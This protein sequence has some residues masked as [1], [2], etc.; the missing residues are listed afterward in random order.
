MKINIDT[1]VRLCYRA[2]HERHMAST[3][4]VSRLPQSDWVRD[5]DAASGD[6]RYPM[7]QSWTMPRET[8]S[9][10][11]AAMKSFTATASQLA[12]ELRQVS[13]STPHASSH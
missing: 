3:G 10:A 6:W 13:W 4:G 7:E 11:E 2:T 8:D 1:I 9:M 12:I 5:S